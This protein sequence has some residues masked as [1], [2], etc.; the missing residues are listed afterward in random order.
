MTP[1]EIALARRI[2]ACGL[3]VPA[4]SRISSLLLSLLFDYDKLTQE[5]VGLDGY[6]EVTRIMW[7]VVATDTG[8]E[9]LPVLTD[10][11]LL[12]WL[13]T[14]ARRL[15]DEPHLRT[16]WSKSG[17]RWEVYGD[18]HK[19]QHIAGHHVGTGD[20]EVEALV[21]ALEAAKGAA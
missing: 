4:Y 13:I 17:Q 20:T 1:E 8:P 16:R 11:A 15:L 5:H 14:E 19:W 21:A 6:D 10:F 9:L 18:S 2:I 7:Q 3:P 12:G